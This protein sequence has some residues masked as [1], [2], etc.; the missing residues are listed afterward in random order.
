MSNIKIK[1]LYIKIPGNVNSDYIETYNHMITLAEDN[2]TTICDVKE[3]LCQSINLGYIN[4]KLYNNYFHTSNDISGIDRSR[5]ENANSIVAVAEIN[6]RKIYF[7]SDIGNYDN[8]NVEID[9]AKE[10]GDIDVYKVSHHGFTSYN[11]NP[12]AL[13]Y[14]KPEYGIVTNTKTLSRNAISIIR[15]TNPNYIKTYYTT[16]G[17]V[18]SSSNGEL[19]TGAIRITGTTTIKAIAVKQG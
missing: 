5:I 1:T 19:Y 9:L 8:N 15:D 12:L 17:T 2:N 3:E 13:S 6:N 7:S 4:I 14:L 16:D 18:P 11:N 10:I